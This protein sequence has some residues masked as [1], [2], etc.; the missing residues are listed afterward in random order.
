MYHVEV[1]PTEDMSSNQKTKLICLCGSS[2]FIESFAVLA[3]KFEKLGAITFSLQCFP[4]SYYTNYAGDNLV[5]A[6]CVSNQ[7][8][9]LHLR[10][11]NLASEIF[12]INVNGYIS[13]STTREIAYAQKLCKPVKYLE[14][15]DSSFFLDLSKHYKK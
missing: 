12:V 13:K 3:W 10:K 15:V 7:I 4:L 6:E 2:R 9:E 14:K 8:D 11:I 5:A 1:Q